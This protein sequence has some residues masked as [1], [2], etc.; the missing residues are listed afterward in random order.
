MSKK[1][2][3]KLREWN[4]RRNYF[5]KSLRMDI[6]RIFHDHKKPRHFDLA[7]VKQVLF[8]RDDDKIGDM[9]VSTSLFREFGKAGFKIDVLA[10]KNNASVIEHN[11]YIR[12]IVVAPGDQND[13]IFLA[14]KLARHQYD[15]VVDM[16]DKISPARLRFIKS[17]NSKSVIGFNKSKYNIYNK[18]LDYLGYDTHITAR[19]SLLLDTM[20]FKNF[21]TDYDLHCSDEIKKSVG[22]FFKTLPGSLKIVI[23][24]FAADTR[25]DLS[26]SQLEEL[27]R[28][29]KEK[30]S[31]A[32]VIIIGM[33]SRIS[34]LSI[35]E[36]HINP[37]NSLSS[38]IEIIR[39]ADLVISPDTSIVHIATAW[40]K[41]LVCLYGNDV[42]GKFINSAVWGPGNTHAVQLFTKDKDHPISSIAVNDII[43]SIEQ[44][45]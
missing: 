21:S 12:R 35:P 27:V 18:S 2:F 43:S 44:L 10:G 33:M 31:G 9:V 3:S 29:I 14:K 7:S 16:G 30:W 13:S 26:I 22:L 19:Y 5:F 17:I 11:P 36:T 24:P 34:C 6:A 1:K 4:R 42:H 23:N 37:F 39:R 20:E 45:I 41:P 8:L 28:R 40:K 32:D 38:A 15:L 25:R